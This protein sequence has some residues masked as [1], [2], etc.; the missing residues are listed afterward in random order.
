MLV[1]VQTKHSSTTRV[2]TVMMPSKLVQTLEK[3]ARRKRRSRSEMIRLLVEEA[4]VGKGFLECDLVDPEETQPPRTLLERPAPQ[5]QPTVVLPVRPPQPTVVI[6][7]TILSSLPPPPR[8]MN[9]TLP[10]ITGS[11]TEV[12]PPAGESGIVVTS[13]EPV[14]VRT[15][16]F[17]TL[18]ETLATEPAR[19]E[20]AS[21]DHDV[22][23]VQ[24]HEAVLDAPPDEGAD[25]GSE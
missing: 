18:V 12:R 25:S 3:F 6:P 16:E 20:T 11:T 13:T 7:P 22:S 15:G 1:V 10:G 23:Q 9:V 14:I 17:D 8:F 4:L 21:V 24:E 2:V 5:P 19:E